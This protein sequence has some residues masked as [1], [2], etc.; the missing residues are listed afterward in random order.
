MVTVSSLQCSHKDLFRQGFSTE[1]LCSTGAR[2]IC[3]ESFSKINGMEVFWCY[4]GGH[5]IFFFPI[6]VLIIFFIFKYTSV[7][8]EEYVAEGI[9]KISDFL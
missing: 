7:V 4:L 9:Q 8:V 1:Y 5:Y 2:M 6:A 3:A